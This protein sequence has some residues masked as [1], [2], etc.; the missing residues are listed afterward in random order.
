MG[1]DGRRVVENQVAVEYFSS[2]T[3]TGVKSYG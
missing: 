1:V 3:H 2:C